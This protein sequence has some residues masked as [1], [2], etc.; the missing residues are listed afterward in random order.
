METQIESQQNRDANAE[1]A[2]NYEI[3]PEVWDDREAA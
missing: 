2:P 1:L 3:A